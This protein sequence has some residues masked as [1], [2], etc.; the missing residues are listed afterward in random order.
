MNQR[1]LF[2]TIYNVAQKIGVDVYVVGGY[3][4]DLILDNGGKGE[5]G[6]GKA[7]DIDF[8]IVGSG[9]EFAKAFDEVWRI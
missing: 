4:R 8:V 3:V 7:K 2:R 5:R 9:L 6:K 1:V